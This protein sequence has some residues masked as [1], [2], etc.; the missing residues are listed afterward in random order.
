METILILCA[1]RTLER[2][3]SSGWDRLPIEL[4]HVLHRLLY[5]RMTTGFLQN[6]FQ[7]TLNCL[8]SIIIAYPSYCRREKHV[9]VKRNA[10]DGGGGFEFRDRR[11]SYHVLYA[12]PST[13]FQPRQ[14]L[15]Y[16]QQELN[17][18]FVLIHDKQVFAYGTCTRKTDHD[19]SRIAGVSGELGVDVVTHLQNLGNLTF[20]S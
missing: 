3:T 12:L 9:V 5:P 2:Q 1:P 13:K 7:G 15:D 14:L 4:L 20:T 18:P 8:P 11:S 10:W 17:V 16:N 6:L 19:A